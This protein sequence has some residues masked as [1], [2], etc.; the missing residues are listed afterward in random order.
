[1]VTEGEGS[2]QGWDDSKRGCEEV[3]GGGGGGGG[4]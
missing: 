4:G 2:E 3:G 1:M